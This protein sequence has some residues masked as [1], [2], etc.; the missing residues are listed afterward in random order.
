MN[1]LRHRY[2]LTDVRNPADLMELFHSDYQWRQTRNEFIR[3]E[4]ICQMCAR[5]KNLQVHHIL[6]WHLRPDLRYEHQNLVTLCADCHLRFGHYNN[7]K[8]YNIEIL[9]LCQAAQSMHRD[10]VRWGSF[11]RIPGWAQARIAR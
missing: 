6:P 9:A 7:W 3:W 10:D 8:D 5:D 1:W 2:R 11:E 4:P